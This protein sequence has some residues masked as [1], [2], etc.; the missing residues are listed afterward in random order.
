MPLTLS[1]RFIRY[2]YIPVLFFGVNGVGLWTIFS[3]LNHGEKT[4]ILL[5]LIAFSTAFTFACERLLPHNASW[6]KSLGDAGRDVKHFFFNEVLSLGPGLVLPFFVVAAIEVQE[7]IWPHEWHLMLQI[8]LVFLIF[9][10]IQNLFHWTA[11]VWPPL[12]RL[13]AVHHSVERMY[14]FNAVLKHPVYQIFSSLAAVVPLTLLGMPKVFLLAL[15]F[16]AVIQLYIQHSNVNYTTGWGK[17]ILSTSEVHRFHHLKGTAGDVNF[18][19][20][21]SFFDHL[22]GN[23]YYDTRKLESKDIGLLYKDYPVSWW[24]QMKAPFKTW[25][26]DEAHPSLDGVVE[27]KSKPSPVINS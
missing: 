6:N 4:A 21:F 7:G 13:H 9:D 24:G 8:L 18:A 22:F 12:W 26:K 23:A 14:G 15:G 20:Y 3:D 2:F 25:Y 27:L 16:V 10:L 1:Q 19:M 5:S 11:H 17:L